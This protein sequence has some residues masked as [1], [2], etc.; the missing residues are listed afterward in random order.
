M[1]GTHTSPVSLAKKLD[2]GTFWF[3]KMKG[4]RHAVLAVMFE[5]EDVLSTEHKGWCCD[6]CAL[7]S[8]RHIS[9]LELR[10]FGP[11]DSIS[12]ELRP[13]T[14]TPAGTSEKA[15]TVTRGNS[16]NHIRLAYV[17]W[18]VRSVRD[19]LWRMLGIPNT[20]PD[21]VLSDK[22]MDT[23]L[24]RVRYIVD[25][26]GLVSELQ[27]ANHLVKY[28]LLGESRV[29]ALYKTIDKASTDDIPMGFIEHHNRVM[30]GMSKQ[31]VL[32]LNIRIED[33]QG[34]GTHRGTGTSATHTGLGA[35]H[36]GLGAIHT[37]LGAIHTGLGAIHT[38]YRACVSLSE[39]PTLRSD[40]RYT[41]RK[42]SPLAG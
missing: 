3:L 38:G 33:S 32:S 2:P 41:H 13:S 12:N 36:T 11:A 7:S 18:R 29:R 10:G 22:M 5:D 24:K 39:G 4:C 27:R 1:T 14:S 6:N 19:T 23:V 16:Y 30:V 25:E 28:S 21:V 26:N 34:E 42:Q 40:A 8:T 17:K 15:P 9:G 35:I 31:M 20:V 37:S